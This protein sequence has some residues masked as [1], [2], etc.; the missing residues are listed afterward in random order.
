M[1][2]LSL[3]AIAIAADTPKPREF[4]TPITAENAARLKSVEVVPGKVDRIL[5]GPGRGEL[6][7]SDWMKGAVVVSESSLRTLRPIAE[8]QK[9]LYLDISPDGKRIAWHSGLSKT[10]TVQNA[11]DAKSFTIN[12]EHDPSG[13]SFSPDGKLIAIGSMYWDP[14]MM[15]AG[16]SELM[17]FDAAGKHL[18]TF[19]RTPPGALTP[20]FSPDGKTLAVGN[21][22]AETILHEA[23]T[24]KILHTLDKKMTQE[25]AFSPDG[26]TLAT[27]YVDGMV[28]LWD[29]ETG[30]L[31]HSV[32]SGCKEVYSL[33]WSPKGDLLATAGLEGRPV[34]WDI[35]ELTK[36]K[37]LDAM[38]WVGQ[39][40][41]TADGTRLLT[42]SATVRVIG[43]NSIETDSR[44]TVWAVADR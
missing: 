2:P 36:L 24:G 29:V 42:A 22:N 16:H 33:D 12:F 21:R 4:K 10:L 18:K 20:A 9:E 23:A 8:G 30:K 41:F 3:L 31:L 32:A 37:E 25:I 34:L 14:K 26:K 19:A 40:R 35:R 43:M 15:G 28:A 1:I 39:I 5:R 7:L 13:T 6:I 17:L 44:I 27:G 11:A 38:D